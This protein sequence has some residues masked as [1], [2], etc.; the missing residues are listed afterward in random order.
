M[1]ISLSC[2]AV[3]LEGTG[4]CV[5]Q[6]SNGRFLFIPGSCAR[7]NGCLCSLE[8]EWTFPSRV[9]QVCEGDRV[10]VWVN[11]ELNDDTTTSLHW[12]GLHQRVTPYMDGTAHITQCPI[13]PLETFR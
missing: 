11:N 9:W 4:V 7:G 8:I 2:L 1:D 10:V 5:A 6:E 12:H 13:Q 3:V